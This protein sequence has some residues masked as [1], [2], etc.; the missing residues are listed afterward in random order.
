MSHKRKSRPSGSV[1]HEIVV[2]SGE[3][4]AAAMA[5]LLKHDFQS[6]LQPSS[7]Q[8]PPLVLTSHTKRSLE[9]YLDD[10]DRSSVWQSASKHR[11]GELAK[12]SGVVTLMSTVNEPVA[13]TMDPVRRPRHPPY[14]TTNRP[15]GLYQQ[16]DCFGCCSQP[17]AT[18]VPH[19]V[20]MQDGTTVSVMSSASSSSTADMV[21]SSA[22][23]A[24][25]Q[26]YL[27]G[28]DDVHLEVGGDLGDPLAST[29][30][31][32]APNPD[33]TEATPIAATDTASR[34]KRKGP[35]N[36][37]AVSSTHWKC[38]PWVLTLPRMTPCSTG[39]YGSPIYYRY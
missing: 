8:T 22:E 34:P 36:A 13:Q 17:N 33:S 3:L 1:S 2:D 21:L 25:L 37:K 12:S 18:H 9:A 28:T 4:D 6:Y 10:G 38:N 32:A 20:S 7:T 35:R 30:S 19:R 26:T 27:C 29:S 14:A 15:L 11:R 5:A 23:E 24:E 39:A 31:S 16:H